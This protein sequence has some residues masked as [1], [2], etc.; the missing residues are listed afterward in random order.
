MRQ[1]L[2]RAAQL[3]PIAGA[4]VT[5]EILMLTLI[6]EY[7]YRA[8]ELL[9]ELEV[10]FEQAKKELMAVIRAARGANMPAANA[11][12]VPTKRSACQGRTGRSP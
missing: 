10:P 9:K 3:T 5:A 8:T 11:E 7:P 6:G 12:A 4:F 1:I 2:Q